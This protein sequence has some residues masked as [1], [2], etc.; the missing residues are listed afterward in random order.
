M[1]TIPGREHV[2][3]D[4]RFQP[5]QGTSVLR[6]WVRR[7]TSVLSLVVLDLVALVIGIMV[8]F[9]VLVMLRGEHVDLGA[10]WLEERRILPV[11]AIALIIVYARARLYLARERR[12]N[13]MRIVGATFVATLAVLVLL[14]AAGSRFTSYAIFFAAFVA[15]SLLAVLLRASHG[16]ITAMIFDL[17]KV[18][19][20]VL[21]VGAP[22]LT[23][24]IAGSLRRARTGDAIP[25]RVV[26][27]YAL[28]DD[29]A[30]GASPPPP[31]AQALADRAADEVIITGAMGADAPVLDLLD[32]CRQL[33]IPVRLAPTATELL[34]HT[35]TAV[36]AP[37]LPLFALNAPVLSGTSFH[38][39]RVFDVVVGGAILLLVSPILAVAAL[40]I[41]LQD[42][43]PVLFRSR[44]VGVEEV[45]FDC[46]KL[47]TMSIDAEAKQADLENRNE[48]DG[49]LFKIKDD[50]RVT[51]IGAFMRRFSI[52]ELP[53]LFNVLRGE[54]SLVGPRPL[55]ER[56]YAL[57]DEVHK[58]RYLVLPGM[59][60]LWQVSGR[61]ELS[62]DE[63]VRLDFSYIES[64]SVWLDLEILLRTLPTVLFRR[65]AY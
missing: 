29:G 1:A 9:A 47:R 18:E 17:L 42:R 45:P 27:S 30:S 31:L 37:G 24:E 50:P 26:G 57:L 41:K 34:T 4:A 48:A 52:D 65:G 36:A 8:A 28:V 53:Q 12:G 39:K 22:E 40:A 6:D 11:A 62:F 46:L 23:A 33:R 35:V 10:I 56:D 14:L 3:R 20:R 32:R 21:L 38:I 16:S 13:A 15:T 5:F 63:L 44:R 51:R 61:S 55:P 49:A 64:W 19:R 7:G 60:G 25:Y 58:R 2:R 54:M 59:T 43:G